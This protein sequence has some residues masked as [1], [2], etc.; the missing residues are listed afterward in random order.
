M[1]IEREAEDMGGPGRSLASS[2]LSDKGRNVIMLVGCAITL[3][4][5]EDVTER[6]GDS[7]VRAREGDRAGGRQ[8]CTY[9]R[10]GQREWAT[11]LCVC[12]KVTEWVGDSTVR[13]RG[14]DSA[15]GRQHCACAGRWGE[16]APALCVREYARKEKNRC[17]GIV[18]HTHCT[19]HL[20]NL[21]ER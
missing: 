3:C 16:W 10:R 1:G 5:R 14:E 12:V 2:A 9:A 7:T 19:K 21:F 6:V 18:E 8:H 17:R 4:V 13:T 11:A 20:L 15:S